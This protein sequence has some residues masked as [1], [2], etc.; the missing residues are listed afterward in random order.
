[1][2]KDTYIKECLVS[3]FI[4]TNHNWKHLLKPWGTPVIYELI[5]EEKHIVKSAEYITQTQLIW[6]IAD[7]C[8]A[9]K[10]TNLM[11]F[12]I[13]DNKSSPM[14]ENTIQKETERNMKS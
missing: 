4:W 7:F 8:L 6:L 2:Q 5:F 1:M 10:D 11:G 14:I 3:K 12:N 9:N 13:Q